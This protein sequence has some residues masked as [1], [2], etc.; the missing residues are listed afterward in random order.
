MNPTMLRERTCGSLRPLTV[1]MVTVFSL[2][3]LAGCER[4]ELDR[5]MEAL[6]KKDGGVKIYETVTLPASEYEAIWK[7]AAT[8]RSPADYYGPDYRAVRTREVLVGK[9]AKPGTGEGRLARL[10][11][12]VYR[13]SDGRLLGEQVQYRRDGGDPFTLGFQPSSAACPH[14]EP[15][16]AKSIF[17]KGE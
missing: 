3:A 7:Y 15:G 14:I 12:A 5:Q 8:A 17:I 11:S 16:L 1:A 13:R 2:I 10:Y 4:Y 6:C 9:N